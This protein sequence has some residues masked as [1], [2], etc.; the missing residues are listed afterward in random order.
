[1]VAENACRNAP[2]DPDEPVVQVISVVGGRFAE[3]GAD[4]VRN[5]RSARESEHV[6]EQ[7]L[8]EISFLL[9]I[10]LYPMCFL[11]RAHS[12][13]LRV[14]RLC[15]DSPLAVNSDS[16]AFC[17]GQKPQQPSAHQQSSWPSRS[18]AWGRVRPQNRLRLSQRCP[19]T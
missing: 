3:E 4:C 13:R 15:Q 5:G 2:A 11:R 9:I 17:Q 10:S 14:A 8:H 7:L 19:R 18:L 1:M 16:R 12:C 6:V